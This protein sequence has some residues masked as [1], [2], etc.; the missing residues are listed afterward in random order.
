MTSVS[1]QE[2]TAVEGGNKPGCYTAGISLFGLSI[3]ISIG[4]CDMTGQP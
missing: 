1:N 4:D 2:Q 3:G